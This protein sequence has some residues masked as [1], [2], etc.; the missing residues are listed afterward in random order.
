MS[1]EDFTLT[2]HSAGEQTFSLTKGA[3]YQVVSK[4]D[5][6]APDGFQDLRTTKVL[7]PI[8]GAKTVNL[9]VWDAERDMYDTGMTEYSAALTRLFP[10]PETRK[11]V[12]RVITK[13]ILNPMIARKG[14]V[15]DPN[16]IEFWDAQDFTIT[17]DHVFNTDKV[18][19]LYA[20]YMLV[21]HGNLAP[22]EFESDPKFRLTAQYSVENKES[23]VD[24]KYKKELETN[25]ATALFFTMLTNNKKELI[26]LLEWMKI[27]TSTDTDDALLNS[28]FTRWLKDDSN[29]N[30]KAFLKTYSEMLETPSGKREL[31][32]YSN[33]V[34]LRKNGKIKQAFNT[35]TLDGEELGANLKDATKKILADEVMTE[36]ILNLLE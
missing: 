25:K 7:D 36:K 32:M 35:V 31:E 8:A 21:L 1:K 13:E 29:Q 23:V 14:N 33:L 22:V 20:L 9:A 19:D 5:A 34:Q 2:L 28:I 11:Q 27:S 24:L 4:F 26:A 6:D 3:L 10:D 17:L 30:P 15:F 16:N 18:E 12:L